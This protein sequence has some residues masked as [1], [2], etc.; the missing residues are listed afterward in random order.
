MSYFLRLV[1]EQKEFEVDTDR[2][3]RLPIPFVS[4]TVKSVH[5]SISP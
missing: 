3:G 2:A 4:G 1:R 5:S